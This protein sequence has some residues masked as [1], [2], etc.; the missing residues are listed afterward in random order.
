[1]PL[2]HTAEEVTY[3]NEGAVVHVGAG[4][5]IEL[6]DA[7]AKKLGSKVVDLTPLGT[8]LFPKGAPIIDALRTNPD[9]K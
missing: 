8:P 4:K 9:A 6:T 7:Q 5:N 3:V 2:F 1:M